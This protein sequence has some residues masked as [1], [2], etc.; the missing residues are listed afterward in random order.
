MKKELLD[1]YTDYLISQNHKATSTGLSQV[2]DGEVSHDQVTR[3]LSRN[4]YDSSNL[5]HMTKPTIRKIETE[6]GVLSLDDSISE[7]PYTDENDIVCWHY[8][9]AKGRVIK[10]INLLS[11]MVRYGDVA[12]PIGYEII[13][14]TCHYSDLETHQEHRKSWVTKNV[15]FRG[16]IQQA[17]DNHVKFQYV[18]ADNWFASKDNMGFVHTTLNK[19]LIFGIKSNR[20]VA[21]SAMDKKRGRFQQVRHLTLEA[22]HALKVYLKGVNFPVQLQKKV[23]KNEN[24]TVG[25]LYLVTDDLTIDADRM[26][27]VYQKRW[28]IE[29][30]HKSIKQNAS[31]SRSPTRTVQTQ[32]NHIFA[33]IV[34]YVKL[35]KLKLKT[36]MNH[37][38]LRYKL[39]LK[40]NQMA[41]K[42]LQ[43]MK[44][45]FA[46]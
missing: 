19:R 30:Y 1:I 7:K 13:E 2:L 46:A 12:L 24:G 18:L 25:V 28:R 42:E 21:L 32:S 8:S 20:T 39:I 9:H 43:L 16:L 36:G 15:L 4:Q 29:E 34:A 23:F 40:A 17:C 3:F 5:W 41:F 44:S 10:G 6:E 11:C 31:L 27:Q 26:Y 35:E 14:K 33:S 22:D 38:A 37:F 45:K